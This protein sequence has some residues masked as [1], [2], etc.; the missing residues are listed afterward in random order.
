MREMRIGRFRSCFDQDV[1]NR[2]DG[3]QRV[4]APWCRGRMGGCRPQWPP[5]QMRADDYWRANSGPPVLGR[6]APKPG[7]CRAPTGCVHAGGGAELGGVDH[8]GSHGMDGP[9]IKSPDISGP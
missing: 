9:E 6:C 2:E 7:A 8:S 3:A 5:R 4:H 1:P